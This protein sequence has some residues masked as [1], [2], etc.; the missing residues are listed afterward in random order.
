MMTSELPSK[1]INSPT[2]KKNQLLDA[3]FVKILHKVSRLTN[4]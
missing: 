3:S 4:H 2:E 1:Q